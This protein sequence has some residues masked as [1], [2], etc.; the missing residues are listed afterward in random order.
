MSS[1][2]IA[3]ISILTPGFAFSKSAAVCFQNALPGP[4]VEL[5]QKV[6]VTEPSSDPPPLGEHPASAPTAKAVAAP[7]AASLPMLRLFIIEPLESF[8]FYV[9]SDLDA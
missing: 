9:E 3:W 4:V 5:C 1:F 2:W 7:M 6:I 8:D